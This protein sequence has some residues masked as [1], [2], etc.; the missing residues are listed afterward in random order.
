M[1]AVVYEP[2]SSL[3]AGSASTIHS[4][5]VRAERGD[6]VTEDLLRCAHARNLR[7]A[8]TTKG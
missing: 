4:S 6:E 3:S 2:N 5:V 1:T 8:S 7:S